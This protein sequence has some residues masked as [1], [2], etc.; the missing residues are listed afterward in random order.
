MNGY[1]VAAILLFTAAVMIGIRAMRVQEQAP[2][3]N[4][5]RVAKAATEHRNDQLPA[6]RPDLPAA[7]VGRVVPIPEQFVVAFRLDPSL[8]RGMY[9]GD[10]WVSPPRYQA[11]QPGRRY[12]LQAK[13]QRVDPRSERSD[14]TSEFRSLDPELIQVTPGD[15]PNEW[16]LVVNG[17]GAGR[18]V[19]S[20]G[21]KTRVL[22]VH[23]WE[24]QNGMQVEITQ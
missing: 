20:A 4:I 17:P 16:S 21:P 3:P 18:V 7:H 11:A 9:L 14:V 1:R 15:K 5:V 19:A 13:M 23:A 8:T 22:N 6:R 10:R 2:K 12:T 24:V